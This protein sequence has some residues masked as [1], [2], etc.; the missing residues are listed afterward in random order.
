M[1]N[2]VLS[3]QHYVE[4]E[5]CEENPA[6][7][8]CKACPGYLCENC[9]GDHER[10][11]MTRNHDIVSLT[12]N[13][14]EMLDMLY[15]SNHAKKKLECYC[16]RCKEPVCTECI[17]QSHNGHSVK[18]LS[19]VYKE[20][21]SSSYQKKKEIEK[22][23]LPKYNELRANEMKKRSAFTKKVDEIEKNINAHTQSLVEMAEKI[24]KQKV[25]CLRKA[26]KEGLDEADRYLD[27]VEKQINQLQLMSEKISASLE[28][29][30][31]LTFFKSFEKIGLETFQK[32]PT[33]PDYSLPDF[34]PK[35]MNQELRM[36]FGE[37]PML[38]SS[39][40]LRNCVSKI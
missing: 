40:P 8:V 30:P 31:G 14:G 25:I 12:S 29:R 38:Q 11:K 4:C 3:A 2:G 20:F 10:K 16:N 9:K 6:T 1:G 24:G 28:A 32:L 23:L 33:Q 19:T 15:C 21:T 5:H 7:F 18:S 35:N 22:V 39:I 27:N 26:E 13:N 36:S 17:I 34:K 37:P